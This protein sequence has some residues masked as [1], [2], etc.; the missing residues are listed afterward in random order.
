[1]REDWPRARCHRLWEEQQ[2]LCFYCGIAMAAPLTQR[3]RH[4]KRLDA[5]TIEHVVPRAHGG[6]AEW[7][8]EVAACRACNAAKG[9]DAPSE[10]NL[11]KLG[12]LKG[13]EVIG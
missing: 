11:R 5:A 13:F 2:G 4:R 9:D 3:L 8:N 6:A 1:M 10:H 7:P 12:R